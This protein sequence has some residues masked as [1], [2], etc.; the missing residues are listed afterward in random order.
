MNS[1]LSPIPQSA[2][3]NP[4]SQDLDH[5]DYMRLPSK[6]R[7]EVEWWSARLGSIQPPIGDN[8]AALAVMAGVGVSTARRKYD[9]FRASGWRGL[10][11]GSAQPRQRGINAE[12]I[13]YWK[14]L[15]AQNQRKCAPAYREFVRAWHAGEI[16]PGMNNA[17]PRHRLPRGFTYDNL[18]H[19]RPSDFELKAIRIGRS[20]AATERPLVFSTRVGLRVGQF[21]VFDDMWHDFKVVML[22]QRRP[23]RLL[24]LHALDLYSGCNFARG[25]KPRMEDPETGQ[26]V[27]LKEDEMLFLLA[28]VFTD[29]GFSEEGT[30]L[31]VEHGTAAVREDVESLLYDLTG[32]KILVKRSGIEGASAFAGHYAGRGKG[33]FRFKAALE[34]LGNLIHNETANLLQ[35][36][37]QTG[38]NSRVNSPEELHGRERRADALAKALIALP[39]TLAMELSQGFLE[40]NKAIA[41]VTDVMERINRRTDHELEGWLEAGL[42]T[43][44]HEVPGVGLLPGSYILTLPPDKRAAVEAVAIPVA[45]R[46]SPREVFDAQRGGLIRFRPEQCA[47]L[48]AGRMAREVSVSGGLIEFQDLNISP[49]PL[50]YKAHHW[51]NGDKFGV[52][53][54]PLA[55]QTAHLFDARGA[56]VGQVEAWQTVRRDDIDGLHRQM[57][58]AAKIER[59]LLAP[60]AQQGAALTRARLQESQRNS[61]VLATHQANSADDD[62]AIDE[63]LSKAMQ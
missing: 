29:H 57:G 34:S 10:V 44:D 51:A 12:F 3:R 37:G 62:E 52:V 15:C 7:V 20:A 60:V 50:R 1:P 8:I 63:A 35:F 13:E 25:L 23:M 36:P 59:E 2:F 31:C 6:V 45:R 26:S 9:A 33:N 55:P 14:A 32:G 18:M 22:G 43:V 30:T 42:T 58:A 54:N 4:H 40:L 48:L 39:R 17:L 47:R 16:I 5:A 46:L 27:G 19:H 56:W 21:M 41:L 28:H 53:V 11:N 49:S 38:S 24:Q 61:Q